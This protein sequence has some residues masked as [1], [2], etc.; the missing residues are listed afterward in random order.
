MTL[1]KVHYLHLDVFCNSRGGGNHL[2]VVTDATGWTDEQM[3]RFAKWTN[4]VETTFLLPPTAENASYKV[5]I[6]T[7]TK[8]IPF[9]GH[10]SIGSAHA[11]LDCQLVTPNADNQIHQ[12]CGAGVLPIRILDP[13]HNNS[14][15]QLL[16]QSPKAKVIRTGLDAHPLL[17]AS[18]AG[19]GLGRLPPALVEGGRHWWLA[20]CES[21]QQLRQWK[22]DHKAILALAKETNCLGICVFA[23]AQDS[24][25]EYQLVVR[26]LPAGV[27]IVEDPASGAANGLIGAYIAHA[28]PN[29]PLAHGYVVSQ[30]REIGHDARLV[31]QIDDK[32][33]IIWIGGRTNT[34]VDGTLQWS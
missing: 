13:D 16:L 28:E 15:R 23:R 20:E 30:G 6:F 11:A 7:P 14:T 33:G 21:E 4:L 17:A 34:I 19:I 18:L 24:N 9:A 22:P 8:E 1:N 26:A 3:Q 32:Q 2:G 29:G 10:P 12:E 5:R 27:G 31:V 25:G